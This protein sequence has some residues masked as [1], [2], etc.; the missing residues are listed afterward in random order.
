VGSP[1]TEK[2]TDRKALSEATH[3]SDDKQSYEPKGGQVSCYEKWSLSVTIVGVSVGVGVLIVYY[4]QLKAMITSVAASELAA[5][6]ALLNAQAVINSERAWVSAELIPDFRQDEEGAWR[7]DNGEKITMVEL[8]AGHHLVYSLRIKNVGR[9]PAQILTY[10]LAYSCLPECITDIS[11][12]S[13]R[14]VI[15]AGTFN[16]FLLPSISVE[17]VQRFKISE[18]IG[19][20]RKEI[21]ELIS[22]AVFHGWVKY[23]NV[24]I[25]DGCS[26]DFCYVYKP[27]LKK[28]EMD[29]RHTKYTQGN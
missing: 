4:L 29:G 20:S 7:R 3:F 9:T 26:S 24:L 15:Q 13:P 8:I 21:D 28:L 14:E 25:E 18:L 19:N 2:P 23:R 17:I 6:A 11:E 12:D 27:S 10:N 22:T 1:C 5:R 16:F